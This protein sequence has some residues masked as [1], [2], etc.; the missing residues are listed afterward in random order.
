[1]LLWASWRA[2]PD[3]Q[4]QVRNS[5]DSPKWIEP[6]QGRDP[7]QTTVQGSTWFLESDGSQPK[8][9]WGTPPWVGGAAC[10]RRWWGGGV[11]P[12][13]GLYLIH[14]LPPGLR[15]PVP[16]GRALFDSGNQMEPRLTSQGGATLGRW[17]CM[18]LYPPRIVPAWAPG[19]GFVSF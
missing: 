15:P 14:L 12:W 13:V 3:F 16:L 9:P 18:H 10:A 6:T 5:S 17:R 19:W 2:Q 1:M 7:P 4:N 8:A 11:Q